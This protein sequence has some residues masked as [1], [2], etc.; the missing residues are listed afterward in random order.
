MGTKNR[1]GVYDRP[2]QTT[3]TFT[4]GICRGSSL[5]T[6]ITP[7]CWE[8]QGRYSFLKEGHLFC[9]KYF[10]VLLTVALQKNI[11]VGQ[12]KYEAKITTNNKSPDYLQ[13]TTAVPHRQYSG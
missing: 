5:L 13:D 12:E 10:N 6:H 9:L 4:G 2:L 8:L 3:I 1:V 7:E 11:P